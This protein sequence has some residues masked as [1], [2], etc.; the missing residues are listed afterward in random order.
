MS[1]VARATI[2][3]L[4][5]AIERREVSPVEATRE[6]LDRIG[7][8]DPQL[9][10][11]ITVWREQALAHAKRAED[12]I[13]MG[14]YR[15]RLHGIP[16]G[17]KDNIAVAG[18]PTTC[19]SAPMTDQ[20]TDYDA[21]VVERFRAAG[22]VIVGKCN[23]HEWAMGGTSCGGPFGDVHNPWDV[24]RIPGGSSGGSAAAV[25]AS[26][27]SGSVGT[28]GWGSIRVPAAYCGV[29]GV[30]PT[31]GLV[32]RFGELPPTS[33][34]TDHLGPIAKDVR[35]AALMLNLLAGYDPR[36][37]TSLHS[38]PADYV[39]QIEA[40][41]EGL[42]IGVPREFFF[43]QA[44]EEVETA[45]SSAI[46]ALAKL[47]AEVRDVPTPPVHYMPLLTSATANESAGALLPFAVRG[48]RSFFDQHIWD[49]VI[50][51]QFV[52]VADAL[53]AARV[54]NM[55][56]REFA[57]LMDEVDLLAMPTTPTTAPPIAGHGD[58]TV[59]TVAFN[60]LGMPAVSVPCGVA[61][62]G[63]PVGVMMVGRHWEDAVVLRA[64]Y[65]VEQATTGGYLTPPLAE[66]I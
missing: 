36:D 27:I 5:P 61:N 16:L 35:D 49:R 44:S 25:N 41:V 11:F 6:V 17:I 58:T 63:L 4:A 51:G 47:G 29:V 15:G 13:S 46:D 37:P 39:R 24:S 59:L 38:T 18:W 52:R 60:Y 22:A 62:D 66:S 56:R 8:L 40:G 14:Q 20:A 19:G 32:S 42:R 50:T 26:M 48:P 21:A 53:K 10:A 12:E 30:K 34:T 3:Q 2:H 57:S 9:H 33:S 64:A 1:D 54:R 23:M 43:D 31:Y 55:L 45:V 65:T 28:D 7:A